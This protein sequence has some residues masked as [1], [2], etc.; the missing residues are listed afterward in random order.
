VAGDRSV[1]QVAVLW[2]TIVAGEC[3]CV[4]GGCVASVASVA[5]GCAVA[6]LWLCRG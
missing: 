2:L 6:V 4:A 1:A 5:G 3:G